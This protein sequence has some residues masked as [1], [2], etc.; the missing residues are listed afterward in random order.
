MAMSK[1]CP[2]VGIVLHMLGQ[3]NCHESKYFRIVPQHPQVH[4]Y[5]T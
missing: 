5:A 4:H 1:T 3:Y 2:R